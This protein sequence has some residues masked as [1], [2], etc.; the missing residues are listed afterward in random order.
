[1]NIATTSSTARI[2]NRKYVLGAFVVESRDDSSTSRQ[3]DN[4]IGA[5]RRIIGIRPQYRCSCMMTCER[6]IQLVQER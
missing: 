5:I 6:N 3:R 2:V 1:M 4:F